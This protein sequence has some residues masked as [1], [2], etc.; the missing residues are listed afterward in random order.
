MSH[1][2]D[3]QA[4]LSL[5]GA[6]GV[7]TQPVIALHES[8]VQ[9]F[10]SLQA[11]GAY[12]QPVAALQESVVQALLSLHGGL[13]VYTQPITGSHVSVVQALLSLQT[14]GLPPTQ[15]PEPLQ[16]SPVVQA[17]PSSHSSFRLQHVTALQSV[18]TVNV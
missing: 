17:L 7:K 15:M 9:A 10:E 14:V 18:S 11:I 12:T 6:L 1:E 4:L 16:A 13:A 2:S 8:V 3:V 5:H